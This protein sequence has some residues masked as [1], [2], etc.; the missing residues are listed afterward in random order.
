MI[1]TILC[2]ATGI[3]IAYAMTMMLA[4]CMMKQRNALMPVA[5]LVF[6][7]IIFGAVFN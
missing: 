5:C 6:G 2:V 3:A 7:I 4:G 1:L